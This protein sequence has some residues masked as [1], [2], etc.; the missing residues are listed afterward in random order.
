M[1]KEA[2]NLRLFGYFFLT[3]TQL[4]ME[5]RQKL[6]IKFKV[7]TVFDVRYYLLNFVNQRF[8]FTASFKFL[9]ITGNLSKSVFKVN[10][11]FTE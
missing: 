9:Q 10:P 2:Q 1:I 5:A 4:I 8:H 3:L 7:D 6:M 11:F